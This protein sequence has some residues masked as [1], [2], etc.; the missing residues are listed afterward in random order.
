MEAERVYAVWDYYDGIRSGIADYLG[1]PHHFEQDWSCSDWQEDFP[2]FQ[3]KPITEAVFADAVEQSEIFC[4]WEEKFHRGEVPRDSHPRM[5]GQNA[6]YQEL[7]ERL[8]AAIIEIVP[9]ARAKG[10]FSRAS[11]ASKTWVAWECI[12]EL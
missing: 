9:S 5:P 7:E 1:N 11:A 3:L 8:Q 6:K 10:K 4:R 2:T 12:A